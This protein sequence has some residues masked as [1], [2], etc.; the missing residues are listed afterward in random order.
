MFRLALCLNV[1]LSVWLSFDI[2]N[3]KEVSQTYDNQGSYDYGLF[4]VFYLSLLNICPKQQSN[5]KVNSYN[6]YDSYNDYDTYESEEYDNDN[7]RRRR[8]RRG[9]RNKCNL[10]SL[11]IWGAVF[12][13]VA[14]G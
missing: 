11:F 7:D 10:A 14:N 3:G 6:S 13:Y 1:F 4:F 5:K 12:S 8:R 9:K 2:T